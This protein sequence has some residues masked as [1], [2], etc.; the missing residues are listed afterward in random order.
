VVGNKLKKRKMNISCKDLKVE[1]AKEY[2]LG[3]LGDFLCA[4]CVKLI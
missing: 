2:F 4:L 3:V 1:N